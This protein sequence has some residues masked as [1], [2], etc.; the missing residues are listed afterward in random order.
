MA[1]RADI[2]ATLAEQHREL[3]QTLTE[4]LNVPAGDPR[5]RSSLKQAAV[6]LACHTAESER[7][8]HHFLRRYVPDD[9]DRLVQQQVT[10]L[11]RAEETMKDLEFTATDS[12]EFD[13]LVRR[14]IA[15]IRRHGEHT[16]AVLFPRLRAAAPPEVL[17]GLGDAAR[18]VEAE[19]TTLRDEVERSERPDVIDRAQAALAPKD[20]RTKDARTT[21]YQQAERLDRFLTGDADLPDM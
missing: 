10:D 11:L 13:P 8:L 21:A 14:L 4:V 3:E 2:V 18:Q 9:A 6:T 16:E 20:T 5:R 12:G 17:A 7:H 15:T 19:A 1:D